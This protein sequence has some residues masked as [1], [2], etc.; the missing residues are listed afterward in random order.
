M[1]VDSLTYRF[2]GAPEEPFVNVNVTNMVVTPT[3]TV[4][5]A[6][7]GP[8]QVDL[9][10]LNP[11]EVRLWAVNPLQRSSV[12]PLKPGDWTKQSIPFSYLS[13]TAISMDNSAHKVQVY[14]DVTG[15]ARIFSLTYVM[16]RYIAAEWMSGDRSQYIQWNVTSNTDVIYHT[17]TLQ[18]PTLFSE[19]GAQAEWGTLYYAMKTVSDGGPFVFVTHGPWSRETVSRTKFLMIPLPAV[20]LTLMERWTTK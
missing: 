18:D 4:I 15:G 13:F 10:F 9:T 6:L 14:S 16:L 20:S 3:Q 8:M 19:V 11:I 1:H 2:L 7:A 17:V 12:Y 5:S